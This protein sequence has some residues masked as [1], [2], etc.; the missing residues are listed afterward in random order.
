MENWQR[1]HV[2][3]DNWE[4]LHVMGEELGERKVGEQGGGWEQN[5]MLSIKRTFQCQTF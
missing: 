5:K 2:M 1:L 4:G 3:G